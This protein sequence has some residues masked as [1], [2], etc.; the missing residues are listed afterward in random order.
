MLI[1]ELLFIIFQRKWFLI[2]PLVC[3][4]FFAILLILFVEPIYVST[5]K[6]W[7]KE[8]F[9]EPGFLKIV[10]SDQ[11][12][13]YAEVQSQIIRSKKVF[14][15]VV[16]KMNLIVPPPSQNLKSKLFG[17]K[18][19]TTKALSPE[20]AHL[21]AVNAMF[22]QVD[23]EIVNKEILAITTKMN[24]P[25]LSLTL[26]KTIL[27]TYLEVYLEI[28][29]HEVNEYEQVIQTRMNEL[30]ELVALS[31]KNLQKFEEENPTLTR[32]PLS[33][34]AKYKNTKLNQPPTTEDLEKILKPSPSLAK[35]MSDLSPIPKL[36]EELALLEMKKNKESLL[37]SKESYEIKK[38]NKLIEANKKLLEFY[39]KDLSQQAKKAIEYQ[40][41]LWEII[42]AR[43][44]FEYILNEFD[45]VVVYRGTKMKQVSSITVLD[46]PASSPEPIQPKKKL[47][48]IT[49]SFLSFI[50]GIAMM[51]IAEIADRSYRLPER[52]ARD[53]DK[54]LFTVTPRVK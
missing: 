46:T 10:R 54:E 15:K 48:I 42:S 51:Y 32:E 23:V 11:K 24:T 5:S 33:N 41:L 31:E 18:N 37:S 8:R 2:I 19:K 20:L 53:L 7:S 13:T 45:K 35:K 16:D 3:A 25:E 9:D 1:K 12:Q 6:I 50:M 26:N 40:R 49:A 28:L 47:T 43:K 14:E 17:N 34:K 30:A 21:K 4:P 22:K 52:M 27:E 36:L 44:R 29:N 38:L 39:L